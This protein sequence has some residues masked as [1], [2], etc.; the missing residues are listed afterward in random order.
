MSRRCE[1]PMAESNLKP[2]SVFDDVIDSNGEPSWKMSERKRAESVQS[3][4]FQHVKMQYYTERQKTR[5]CIKVLHQSSIDL[6]LP[7]TV[8]T[9]AS[10][11]SASQQR[12]NSHHKAH[13]SPLTHNSHPALPAASA[14]HS[15]CRTRTSRCNPHTTW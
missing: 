14:D 9:S 2:R 5:A 3:C 15:K 13:K 7:T 8:Y 12:K 6:V 11:D 10:A 1:R 4:V